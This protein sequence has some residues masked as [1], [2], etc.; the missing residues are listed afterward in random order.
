VLDYFHANRHT[1][2]ADHHIRVFDSQRYVDV[3]GGWKDAGGDYGKYLSHLSYAN[4][5]NP[6]HTEKLVWALA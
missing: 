3:W 2:P 5:F 6:Q 1:K 4:F